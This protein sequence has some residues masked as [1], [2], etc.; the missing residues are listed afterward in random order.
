[1]L[2]WPPGNSRSCQACCVRAK[3]AR[4]QPGLAA[5]HGRKYLNDLL[6]CVPAAL[7]EA[8]IPNWRAAVWVMSSTVMPR[9]HLLCL[10]ALIC[11]C[12][13][14]GARLHTTSNLLCT[15]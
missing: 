13:N 14:P 12:T 10:T 6:V 3:V 4:W 1:V 2:L 5:Q 11:P 7:G 9:N 8:Y 15:H